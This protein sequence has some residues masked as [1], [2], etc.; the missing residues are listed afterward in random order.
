[1]TKDRHLSLRDQHTHREKQLVMLTRLSPKCLVLS[2]GKGFSRRMVSKRQLLGR[3]SHLEC[4]LQIRRKKELL[5]E[6]DEGKQYG[7]HYQALIKALSTGKPCSPQLSGPRRTVMSRV[8]DLQ[9][10]NKEQTTTTTKTRDIL[11]PDL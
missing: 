3:R 5:R 11:F 9:N 10:K 7:R 6:R 1:M 2:C 8:H 4:P